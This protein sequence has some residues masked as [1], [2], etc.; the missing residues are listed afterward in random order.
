MVG[1]KNMLPKNSMMVMDTKINMKLK[2]HPIMRVSIVDFE[3]NFILRFYLFFQKIKKK[4]LIKKN[5]FLIYKNK[6]INYIQFLFFISF[7]H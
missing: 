7:T 4:I 2:I 1:Y 6:M 5:K 3:F